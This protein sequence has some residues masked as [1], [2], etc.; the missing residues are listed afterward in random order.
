MPKIFTPDQ[1]GLEVKRV[2]AGKLV[3]IDSGDTMQVRRFRSNV[4]TSDPFWSSVQYFQNWDSLTVGT[5]ANGQNMKAGGT[6]SLVANPTQTYGGN[7]FTTG[8]GFLAISA[9]R[10]RSTPNS[11]S[12]NASGTAPALGKS[13]LNIAGATPFSIEASFWWNASTG[14]TGR[15]IGGFDSVF[16]GI[17]FSFI[18]LTDGTLQAQYNNTVGGTST[19][20]VAT[21]PIQTWTDLAIC[22]DGSGTMYF[23]VNGS[24][25][26]TVGGMQFIFPAL[27]YMTAPRVNTAADLAFMDEMRITLGVCRYTASYTPLF[28]LPAQ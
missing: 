24:L 5:V 3:S 15:L 14:A 18:L 11:I 10:S 27:I 7:T 20:N 4:P 1:Y 23:F 28:P 25:V 8:T 17:V 22:R 13:G 19:I 21:I 26:Q 16:G 2:G 12:P 9:T 6:L